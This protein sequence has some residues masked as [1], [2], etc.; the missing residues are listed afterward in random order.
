M[1]KLIERQLFEYMFCNISPFFLLLR[2]KLAPNSFSH[3]YVL[4]NFFHIY[5]LIISIPAEYRDVFFSDIN[6]S[7]M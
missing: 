1:D 5:K 4:H 2:P 7:Q 3:S 6:Y